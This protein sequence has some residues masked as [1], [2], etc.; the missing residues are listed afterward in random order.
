MIR[1]AKG[2]DIPE[3]AALYHSIWHETHAPLMPP[4]EIARRSLAFFVDRMTA[5]SDSTLVTEHNGSIVGFS[6]W[7]GSVLGQLFVAARHRGTGIAGGLLTAAEIEM[8]KAGTVEAELYCVAGNQ[9]ARRFYERM[10]WT[11]RERL[12]DENTPGAVPVLLMAKVLL[13]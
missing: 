5:V 1:R 8:A 10:G 3:V 11:I 9:R 12:L 4:A 13:R 6:A 2:S 7:R